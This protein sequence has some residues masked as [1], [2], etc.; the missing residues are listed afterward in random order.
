MILCSTILI[1][2]LTFDIEIDILN[3]SKLVSWLC[4]NP[5]RVRADPSHCR[6]W[7]CSPSTPS[8]STWPP[9]CKRSCTCSW[10]RCR[11]LNPLLRRAHRHH[12]N[13]ECQQKA[14]KLTLRKADSLK[15]LNAEKVIADPGR[16]NQCL[17]NFVTN[18]VK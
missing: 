7:D 17:I 14:I 9:K 1:L 6:T 8:P 5:L 4:A 12:S 10:C 13:S 15:E 2:S 16:L 3:V 11:R 18:G